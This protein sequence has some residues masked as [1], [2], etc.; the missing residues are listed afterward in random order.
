M[1]AHFNHATL[2]GHYQQLFCEKLTELDANQVHP[3]IQCAA[4]KSFLF[5]WYPETTT[6]LMNIIN[7][8]TLLANKGWMP[9]FF[10]TP[11]IIW[12][13]NDNTIQCIPVDLANNADGTILLN[14][15]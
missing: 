2:Y 10:N 9:G 4:K 6:P 12:Y 8:S 14:P 3:A 15:T 7:D 5:Y 13:R 11:F 1:G